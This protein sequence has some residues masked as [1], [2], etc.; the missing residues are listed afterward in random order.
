MKL[1]IKAYGICNLSVIPVRASASDESEIVTQL[2]FGDAV[3]VLE[4]GQPWIKI[5]FAQDNYDGWMDFKQLTYI[6]S[7]EYEKIT[8]ASIQYLQ[9]PLLTIT[10]PRGKQNIMLGSALVN[11]TGNTM[12]FGKEIYT[13]DQTVNAGN[14]NLLQT[15]LGY[16]NTPYLWGGKSI[17]GIDCSGLVQNVFKVH[18]TLLPRDASEQVHTGELIEYKDRE[19]GDVPFFINAKGIVHHVGILTTKDEIIHAAGCV[20]LDPFDE[21]GIFR[22]DLEVYTHHYQSIRRY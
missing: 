9:D 11:L 14:Q 22:K 13:I 21:K 19:I 18:G 20:R 12:I 5:K 15:A 2:L 10:G 1:E 17:F 6:E 8:N 3:E 7:E 16:L 4:K